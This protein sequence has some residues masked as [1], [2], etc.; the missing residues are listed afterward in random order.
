MGNGESQLEGIVRS[1]ISRIRG[2]KGE[3]CLG[4]FLQ[5]KKQPDVERYWGI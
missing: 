4:T 2:E 3:K 5:R 1:Q